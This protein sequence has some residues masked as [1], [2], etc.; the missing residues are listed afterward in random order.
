MTCFAASVAF[1]I[2]AAFG[3]K[4]AINTGSVASSASRQI[5]LA[6]PHA[7]AASA[8]TVSRVPRSD[9][10]SSRA[11]LVGQY[12]ARVISNYDGDTLRAHVEV[13]PSQIMETTI[14]L[15]G[16]DTPELKAPCASEKQTALRARDYV[17]SLTAGKT[18]TLSEVSKG[19]YYGRVVASI[20][21]EDGRSLAALLMQEGL[22]KP[23]GG[24][25]RR[26]LCASADGPVASA[27]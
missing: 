19:K 20:T 3:S 6:V 22:G 13:W 24:G 23:Y 10:S 7:E 25:R 11:G 12:S 17:Q 18:V 16:V 26:N 21:L 8:K 5:A 27:L 4:L 14:R 2:G 15:R 1:C 9:V